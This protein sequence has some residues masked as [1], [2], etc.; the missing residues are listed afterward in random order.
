MIT[1]QELLSLAEDEFPIAEY[2]KSQRDIARAAYVLGYL[3][4][5]KDLSLT[6]E[7]IL[8]II[9]CYIQVQAEFSH[10]R[11]DG[12]YATEILKRYNEL[13]SEKR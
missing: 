1:A 5:E 9:G 13:K 12:E 3:K 2:E 10:K 4:A 11:S 8:R 6:T 7:D